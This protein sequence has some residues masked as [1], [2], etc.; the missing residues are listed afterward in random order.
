[1]IDLTPTLRE[2]LKAATTRNAKYQQFLE[3]PA[4]PVAAKPRSPREARSCL[5]LGPA[6]GQMIEVTEYG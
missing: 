4:I 3:G 5:Y 2:H 6:T 1:M